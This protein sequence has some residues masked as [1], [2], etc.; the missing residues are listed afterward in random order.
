M[1]EELLTVPASPAPLLRRGVVEEM[2]RRGVPVALGEW[3][4]CTPP[5]QP[6]KESKEAFRV[7]ERFAFL[8]GR[9]GRGEKLLEAMEGKIRE[10]LR[11]KLFRGVTTDRALKWALVEL[12]ERKL[13]NSTLPLVAAAIACRAPDLAPLVDVDSAAALRL[14]KSG[15]NG[16]G[17][18]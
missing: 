3:L 4:S 12:K 18:E 5:P 17:A 8:F 9:T 10:G 2:T 15:W 16:K 11:R 13:D 1:K 6:D 14:L 7:L